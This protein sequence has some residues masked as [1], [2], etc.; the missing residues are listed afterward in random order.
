MN[1]RSEGRFGAGIARRL[2]ELH[3]HAWLSNG[4]SWERLF[5]AGEEIREGRFVKDHG[6]WQWAERETEG[7]VRAVVLGGEGWCA[8]VLIPA[9]LILKVVDWRFCSCSDGVI[10]CWRRT[11]EQEL[12][13]AVVSRT[14]VLSF[15]FLFYF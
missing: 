15:L 8:R 2:K 11:S 6:Y 12:F 10:A 14:I 1:R 3:V 5:M 7:G 13:P 4:R 9:R